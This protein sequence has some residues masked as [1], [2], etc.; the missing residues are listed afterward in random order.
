MENQDL[1]SMSDDEIQ[2][3]IDRLENRVPSG[4]NT[5]STDT[6]VQ[7]EVQQPSTEGQ[8]QMPF[9][10]RAPRP[11]VGGFAQDFAQGMWEKAAPVVGLLD[12]ATDLVNLATPRG[13]PN[14]P[15]VPEYESKAVEAIR[16]IS[17]LIIPSLGLRSMA[18]NAASKYHATGA[19]ATKAPWLYKLGNRQSFQAIA[20]GGIDIGTGGL[21]D[22]VAE[23][24]QQDDNFLGTLKK[25]WPRT[26]Q[27]IPNSIATNVDDTPGEKRHKNVTEGAIF[28]VMASVVEGVAYLTGAGRSIKRT[29]QFIPKDNK[30][31]KKLEN[32]TKDEFTDIKF[33]DKPVEDQVLRNYARKEKELNLLNEYYA[34]NDLPTIDW[35]KLDEGETLVRTKDPDGILGAMADEAHIRNPQFE[36]GWGRIGNLIHE[37]TRKE[38]IKL[39]NLSNR[40]LVSE[41]TRQIKEGGVFSKRLKSNKLITAKMMD[42]AGKR[43]A[44]TLLHPRVEPEEII[45]LLGEFKGAVD[46]SAVRIVGK[47]GITRAIKQLQQQMLD[48]DAHKA[49]AY[50]ATAEGGQIADMSEG[51]RLMEEGASIHRTIDL[52]ADRLEVLMVTFTGESIFLL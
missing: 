50:L 16:D 4:T 1:S 41:L 5:E 37:A 28:S 39:E 14:I 10:I 33:S 29:N 26:Y 7:P 44:A 13:I 17:G 42:D 47:K 24:N 18:I 51:I 32:L 27:W 38:G 21:V 22:Y 19:M 8:Q 52:M 3:E 2:A 30:G 35:N 12:T 31:I 49:R 43:L 46:E 25:Y 15:K 9:G 36:S 40:T 34:A 20:K 11:G 48:L 45:G 23:Q 6:V